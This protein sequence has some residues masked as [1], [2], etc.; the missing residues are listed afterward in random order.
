MTSLLTLSTSL[1][2]RLL[3]RS[4]HDAR[5]TG[6]YVI[7]DMLQRLVELVVAATTEEGYL[8]MLPRM[9][10]GCGRVLVHYTTIWA[11]RHLL[12]LVV[13]IIDGHSGQAFCLVEPVD[14]IL[15]V[16]LK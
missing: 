12:L 2:T 7:E 9:T 14:H 11:E 3:F 5:V 8:Q 16:I 13:I 1:R 6:L 4:A 15:L 10:I